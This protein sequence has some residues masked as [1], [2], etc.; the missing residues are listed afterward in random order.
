MSLGGDGR[1]LAQR[2][3]RGEQDAFEEFF[4]AYFPPLFRFASVR[5]PDA[6]AAEEVV[7]ATLCRGLS[8]LHTYRGEAA[9]FTW[10][11]TLCRHEI[12]DWY[13]R[14]ARRPLEVD[15][16]EELPEVRAALESLAA[17]GA[18]AP[19]AALRRDE[20]RRLVQT[21]LDALPDR[22]ADALEWKY[23]EGLSVAEVGERLGLGVKAAESLLSRA[24]RAFRD[25]FLS[26]RAGTGWEPLEGE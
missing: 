5:L 13:E 4:A 9:L 25:G 16:V 22:Y 1:E 15:L 6:V 11:C 21:I 24:R 2:M 3:L 10:F 8:K 26:L 17:E 18:A 23:M 14:R 19:E 12:G 20:L 7:Q